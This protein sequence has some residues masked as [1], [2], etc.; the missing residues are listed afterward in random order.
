MGPLWLTV[1]CMSRHVDL[2][3]RISSAAKVPEAPVGLNATG[4][5]E[6]HHGYHS[7]SSGRVD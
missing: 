4:P 2:H 6:D 5:E 7:G 3:S 1:E